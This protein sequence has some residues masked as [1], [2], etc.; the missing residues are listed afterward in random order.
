MRAIPNLPRRF[1]YVTS[2]MVPCGGSS[3]Y[4]VWLLRWRAM[5]ELSDTQAKSNIV[6]IEDEANG[7]SIL[8][9]L[10]MHD[11]PIV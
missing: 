2:I 4:R 1:R 10:R 6:W 3:A 11:F 8:R 7:V 9:S 5:H